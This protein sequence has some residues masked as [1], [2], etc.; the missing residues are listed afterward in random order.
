MTT[1]DG[2]TLSVHDSQGTE[3]F[4]DEILDLHTVAFRP[5]TE[6][7]SRERV[8]KRLTGHRRSKGF[9]LVAARNDMGELVGFIYG[10]VLPPNA[11]WWRH[12]EPPLSEQFLGEDKGGDRTFAVND[13]AVHPEWRHQGIAG[14]MHDLIIS[15]H[16]GYRF[17]LL[18]EADNAPART[19]YE[20]WGYRFVGRQQPFLDSPI[21]DN[22][23][24]ER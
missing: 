21:F 16:P 2:V 18:V 11:A 20:K 22:L 13:I 14:A 5:D 4:V 9:T 24:L 7:D 1:P 8:A 3:P 19:A 23:V 12:M 6:F 17:T 15:K 10:Y